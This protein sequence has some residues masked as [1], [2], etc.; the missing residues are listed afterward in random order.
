MDKWGRD[1]R[2]KGEA[3]LRSKFDPTHAPL[4]CLQNRYGGALGLLLLPLTL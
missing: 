1:D 3:K 4:L 2:Y